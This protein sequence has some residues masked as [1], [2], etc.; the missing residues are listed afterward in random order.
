MTSKSKSKNQAVSAKDYSPILPSFDTR[1]DVSKIPHTDFDALE[2][3]IFSNIELLRKKDSEYGASWCRR[4]GVGAFFT[5][6]R[7]VDR[8]EEQL[9]RVQFNILDVNQD[10]A[11]TESLD[12]T[13]KDLMLY[14]ALVLEKREAIRRFVGSK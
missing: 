9:K 8:L 7:K 3:Y 2:D 14:L 10:P 13:M 6:W 5:V 12:E 1:Y 11:S 4:G